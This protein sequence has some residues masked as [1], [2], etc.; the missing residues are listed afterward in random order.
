MI[1]PVGRFLS[2]P[3]L[4]HMNRR[5][6]SGAVALGLFVAFLPMPA[7]MLVAAFGAILIRV[8]LALSVA[9]VW[10]S[11]PITIPPMLYAAFWVGTLFIETS[12]SLPADQMTLSWA[13]SQLNQ[14]WAPL[15][16]GSL[17]LGVIAAAIGFTLVR[18][19]WRLNLTLHK[20]NKIAQ[21]R[22]RLSKLNPLHKHNRDD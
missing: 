19:L 14:I 11:N 21:R 5:S 9:M 2:N 6:V 1:R 15:L 4:W 16:L 7:Q 17:I 3:N 22:A 18:L 13:M 8:N 20:R 12:L 10:V